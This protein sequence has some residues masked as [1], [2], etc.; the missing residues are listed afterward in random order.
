MA[1]S[2]AIADAVGEMDKIN[3]S[4]AVRISDLVASLTEL[5][6]TP[7]SLISRI[8]AILGTGY[9]HSRETAHLS[10]VYKAVSRI[11][12]HAAEAE[13]VTKMQG[14]KRYLRAYDPVAM[15]AIEDG[16]RGQ[17]D[18]FASLYLDIGGVRSKIEAAQRAG[19]LDPNRRWVDADGYRLS[20]RV[21]M[22][23][24]HIRRMID[25]DIRFAVRNGVGPATLARDLNVY[26]N[27]DFAP[28]RY[29]RN[30]R[31]VQLSGKPP[32]GGAGTSATR[33][34]AR[35]EMQ[36]IAHQSTLL[37]GETIDI[38]GVGY[39]WNLSPSHPKIDICDNLARRSSPGYP[40]GVYARADVPKIPHTNC[41]CNLS[42]WV[43]SRREVIRQ[44]QE[45]YGL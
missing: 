19:M 32:R 18:D 31:I 1:L 30:G 7:T 22:R 14:F 25:R 21:W 12:M 16:M 26:L 40:R 6:R 37:F 2:D 23:G 44:L 9:G 3:R 15:D 13:F 42:V 28:V 5:P 43:P 10:A 41:L 39:R 17:L 45:R 24:N 29:E 11:E 34:L 36:A 35:T 4:L 33:S 38:D 27:P 8:S 20:D